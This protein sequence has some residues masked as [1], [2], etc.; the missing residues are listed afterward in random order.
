VDDNFNPVPLAIIPPPATEVAPHLSQEI[1]EGIAT[2]FLQIQ[3][4]SVSRKE[5]WESL[6]L[7]SVGCITYLLLVFG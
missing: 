6:H 5:K 4:E 2:G 7:S 1:I 3:P